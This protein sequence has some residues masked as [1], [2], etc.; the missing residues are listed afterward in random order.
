MTTERNKRFNV[1][2]Y[3]DE[4]LIIVVSS[5]VSAITSI[6]VNSILQHIKHPE[7]VLVLVIGLIAVFT[8][9]LGCFKLIAR[10]PMKQS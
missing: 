1:G 6:F 10:S 2:S 9:V 4:G 8:L 3:Q 7:L 5:V